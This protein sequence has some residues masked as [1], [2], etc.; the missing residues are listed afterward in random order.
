MNETPFSIESN[1]NIT[2]TALPK[3]GVSLRLKFIVALTVI[4]LC[5]E[6]ITIALVQ[7]TLFSIAHTEVKERGISI[8]RNVAA[9]SA[10][11]IMIEN[12]LGIMQLLSRTKEVEQDIA[13]LF[14]VDAHDRVIAH[15]L[16]DRFPVALRDANPLPDDATESTL[17]LDIENE[18]VFDFAAPVLDG[19]LGSVH[20]GISESVIEH[21]IKETVWRIAMFLSLISLI[22]IV[23]GFLFAS[24]IIKPLRKLTEAVRRIGE[25]NF[26]VKTDVQ[27]DDEI[28]EL[29]QVFDVM[30]DNL[31][32][33]KTLI[34]NYTKMLEEKVRERTL[35]LESKNAELQ[36]QNKF[37]I[38]R[39][40]KMIELK[41]TIESLEKQLAEKESTTE[42][43]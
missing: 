13:Y 11:H 6:L 2:I 36:K 20:V 37:M 38:D 15:T 40:L 43:L 29:A 3:R 16:E 27:S 14:I 33:T 30:T 21:N 22:G 18:R 8:A 35:E 17:L 9:N 10:D 5:I 7:N 24:S 19:S 32:K 39:E 26:T 31:G 41:H 28:G 1:P 4:V 42:G 25:G 12:E 23:A 34:K